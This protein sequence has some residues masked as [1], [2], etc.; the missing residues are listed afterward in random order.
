[1]NASPSLAMV[2]DL[3]RRLGA[4]EIS[5]DAMWAMLDCHIVKCHFDVDYQAQYLSALT[6][7]PEVVPARNISRRT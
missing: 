6:A 1:M 5:H 4:G 3:S 2:A 7:N